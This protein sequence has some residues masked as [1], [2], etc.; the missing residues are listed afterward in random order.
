MPKATPLTFS[1]GPDDRS[2]RDATGRVVPVP[3]GWVLLPPGDAGLTRRVKAAGESWTV[4]ERVGRRTFSR[5]V[6]APG[7]TVAAARDD[8]RAERATP[9]YARKQVANAARREREQA[10]YVDEFRRAVLAF[11]AFSPRHAPLAERLAKAVADHAT[12]VGSGTVARTERIP[13]ERR[14]ESAVIAWMRHHTTAYDHMTIARVKGERRAVRRQLAER[15]RA[16]LERYRR[17]D[18]VDAATCPLQRALAAA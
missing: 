18:A 4:A 10:E 13:V 15:S 7:A 17:G 5:G 1:P 16:V 14:A 12:P 3:A 6:W 9:A 11:L 8:L 2:V